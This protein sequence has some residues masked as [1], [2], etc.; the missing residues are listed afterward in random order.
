MVFRFKL[1]EKFDSTSQPWQDDSLPSQSRRSLVRKAPSPPQLLIQRSSATTPNAW[2]W[3]RRTAG[4]LSWTQKWLARQM[5]RNWLTIKVPSAPVHPISPGIIH[6]IGSVTAH[7]LQ[8]A[9]ETIWE[10]IAASCDSTVSVL[11]LLVPQTTTTPGSMLVDMYI[12][13][14]EKR[15]IGLIGEAATAK[16]RLGYD[17]LGSDDLVIMEVVQKRGRTGKLGVRQNVVDLFSL[18]IQVHCWW[19]SKC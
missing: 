17:L 4:T 7:D 1:A 6:H 13:R 8:K 12:S 16:Y 18:F 15:N 10:R 5:T 14:S 3:E 2:E 9:Q 11:Q 19:S